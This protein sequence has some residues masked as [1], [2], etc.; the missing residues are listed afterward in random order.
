M[1]IK[2]YSSG[3]WVKSELGLALY[4]IILRSIQWVLL[5]FN[6]DPF[7][8]RDVYIGLGTASTWFDATGKEIIG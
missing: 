8:D 1:Q 4:K 2:L 3:K 6:F 5:A 7:P